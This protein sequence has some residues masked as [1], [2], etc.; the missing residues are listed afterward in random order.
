MKIRL[1]LE[2][3]NLALHKV[4][5]RGGGE[6]NLGGLVHSVGISLGREPAPREGGGGAP[7]RG[8]AVPLTP[9]QQMERALRE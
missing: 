1:R 5:G 8:R 4:W 3:L 7:A 9:L 2:L 6:M